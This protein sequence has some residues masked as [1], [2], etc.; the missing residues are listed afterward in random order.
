CMFARSPPKWESTP[1][2]HKRTFGS[3]LWIHIN[4]LS[5]KNAARGLSLTLYLGLAD[6]LSGRIDHA[7]AAPLQRDIDRGIMLH[8]CP[9]MLI[10][11]TDLRTPFHHHREGQ[12]RLGEARG[13][14]PTRL[15]HL[16]KLVSSAE[17]KK[18][19]QP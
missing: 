13:R 2:P 12:P 15:P 16:T 9:S 7:N 17:P 6:D 14:D 18:G 1:S 3:A 8:G 4:P 11:G 10:V 5:A 19:S